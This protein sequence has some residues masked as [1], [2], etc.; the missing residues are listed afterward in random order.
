MIT[1]ATDHP[2]AH[3][4]ALGQLSELLS[5]ELSRQDFLDGKFV[6]LSNTLL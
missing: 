5:N 3:L 1:L 4:K 6:K 2:N